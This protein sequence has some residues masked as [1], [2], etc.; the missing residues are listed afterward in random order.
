MEIKILN[1]KEF[2]KVENLLFESLFEQFDLQKFKKV[3]L[4]HIFVNQI[5]DAISATIYFTADKIV[6]KA[7]SKRKIDEYFCNWKIEKIIYKDEELNISSDIANSIKECDVIELRSKL[8][9]INFSDEETRLLKLI[10]HA[11]YIMDEIGHVEDDVL[12]KMI[13]TDIKTAKRINYT[14]GWIEQSYERRFTDPWR[15]L[16][17]KFYEEN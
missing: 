13:G 17:L 14:L 12:A 3:I 11:V 4:A 7:N 16:I 2:L 6:Y 9:Y 10:E 8:D 5:K 15:K 1:R